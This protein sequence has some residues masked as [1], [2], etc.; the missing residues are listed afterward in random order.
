MCFGKSLKGD[1]PSSQFSEAPRPSESKY[2]QS[3]TAKMPQQET[4]SP[5]SGPPPSRQETYAPP[6]GPPPSHQ[7]EGYAPPPG[8]PP[9]HHTEDY[10]P[11]P[12][13]PPSKGEP[14]HDWQ[15][16]VPDTSLLPPPPS[17]GNQQSRTN[18]ATEQE[19]EQGEAW[20]QQNPMLGPTSLGYEA[21]QALNS[22]NIGVIRPRPYVGDLERLRAGIWKGKTKSKSPDSCIVSTLPLYSVQAHSP[23]QTRASKT[24][25]YEV[26]ISKHNRS[27]VSLAL[28]FTAPPYPTFRL[29]GWHR[30]CLAVHGDDGSK[31]INDRWGGKDFTSPFKPGQ[32]IGIGMTFTARNTN[33]PPAYGGA[34]TTATTPIDVEIFLTKDGRRDGSWNL[35]EEGDAVEDL[36]VTGLE[37]MHDLYAAIGTFE[38]VDFEIVF[39]EREWMY[40]P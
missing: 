18:N 14:Y 4:Y 24:S 3:G 9:S 23:I 29:P 1:D 6:S 22:G 11:P 13:P 34:Q 5:P 35:H 26:K 40:H 31:Y 39:D 12:G 27:E 19:A 8:P 10:A 38:S 36:P 32:T 37:G 21:M 33:A 20:C 25:Y 2:P 15:T 17:L 30:G 28:G 7:N 16:A